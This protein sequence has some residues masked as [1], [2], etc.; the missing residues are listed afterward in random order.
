M[1]LLFFWG[2]FRELFPQLGE[3]PIQQLKPDVARSIREYAAS[4]GVT[5]S[6]NFF[7]VMFLDISSSPLHVGIVWEPTWKALPSHGAV[8]RWMKGR[9]SRKKPWKSASVLWS[10]EVFVPFSPD[11]DDK[12]MDQLK[13]GSTLSKNLL[14]LIMIMG[15]S[16][17]STILPKYYD[18]GRLGQ[19]LIQAFVPSRQETEELI[20]SIPLEAGKHLNHLT[21]SAADFNSQVKLSSRRDRCRFYLCQLPLY[22]RI[23]SAARLPRESSKSRSQSSSPKVIRGLEQMKPSFFLLGPLWLL[24]LSSLFLASD[25]ASSWSPCLFFCFTLAWSRL[26]LWPSSYD[27][28]VEEP[29]TTLEI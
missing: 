27:V 10:P 8:K 5:F 3:I 26:P 11:C 15:P 29:A 7:D 25:L 4:L 9:S 12:V 23:F 21:G 24:I 6:R 13:I 14:D 19:K 28:V 1:V 16:T 2:L 20:S 22:S 17:F 18:D